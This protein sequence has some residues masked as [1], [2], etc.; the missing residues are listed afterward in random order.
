MRPTVGQILS[1]LAVTGVASAMVAAPERV[2][3]TPEERALPGLELTVADE[4]TVVR[5][6]PI[7]RGRVTRTE[8]GVVVTRPLR[9]SQPLA[10]PVSRPLRARPQPPSAR[11]VV[12][13]P[14]QPPPV[15][16]PPPA[17]PPPPTP[18]PPAPPAA[19][20]P[21]PVA[22]AGTERDTAR[23][24]KPKKPKRERTRRNDDRGDRGDREERDEGDEGD[25]DDT[26]DDDSRE[27]G[28][29]HR[30]DKDRDH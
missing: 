15:V 16:A 19:P 2:L 30:K 10:V 28:H 20:P 22:M 23:R 9:R 25:R 17:A 4:Q 12:P 5:A 14:P 29:G 1:G 18:P 24:K 13:K 11:R 7:R 3:V 21:P 26:S 8:R 27:H 6:E